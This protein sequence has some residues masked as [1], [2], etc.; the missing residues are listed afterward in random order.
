LGAS[1]R[2]LEILDEPQEHL[3]V[4]PTCKEVHKTMTGK[5][6]FNHVSFAYPS[7]PD[8]EILKDIN[9]TANAGDKIAIVGPSGTGNQ[10]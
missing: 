9:F 6:S 5:L 2:I 7:R 8:I 4:K 3:N 1:E 10:Q